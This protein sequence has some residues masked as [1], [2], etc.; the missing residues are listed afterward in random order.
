MFPL[1]GERTRAKPASSY[2][3]E[4]LMVLH[5]RPCLRQGRPL[6]RPWL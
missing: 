2:E 3:C 5:G 4:Q 1:R 6:L